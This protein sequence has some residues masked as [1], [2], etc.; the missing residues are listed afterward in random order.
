MYTTYH[1]K[2]A[3]KN[4][5]RSKILIRKHKVEM[6]RAKKDQYFEGSWQDSSLTCIESTR[7][8]IKN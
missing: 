7:D 5:L 2:K 4:I 8:N 3:N 1:L 6:N